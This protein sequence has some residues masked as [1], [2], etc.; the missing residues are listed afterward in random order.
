MHEL[1]DSI[2]NNIY[3]KKKSV[4]VFLDLAKAFDKI[5]IPLLLI[6]LENIDVRGF[7]LKLFSNYLN[8]RK[9]QVNIDERL[10]DVLT[11]TYGVTQGGILGSTLFIAYTY[12]LCDQTY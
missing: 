12:D 3:Q 1:V 4:T 2:I 10:S 8:E 6:K 5:S 11:V 9:Q 7:P